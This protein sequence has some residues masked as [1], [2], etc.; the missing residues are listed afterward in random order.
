MRLESE[1]KT[2]VTPSVPAVDG[3]SRIPLIKRREKHYDLMMGYYIIMGGF[4]TVTFDGYGV[5]TADDIESCARKGIF[6]RVDRRTIEDKSKA[7]FLAKFLV[8]FQV[9]WIVIEVSCKITFSQ[10]EFT[11]SFI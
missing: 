10:L 5:L 11:L 3:E 6:H 1:T 8:C 2:A 7:D 4:I 9:I